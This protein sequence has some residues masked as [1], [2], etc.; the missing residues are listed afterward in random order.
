MRQF[1][2]PYITNDGAYVM[3][4]YNGTGIPSIK[5][6]VVQ[7][8]N[9]GVDSTFIT[10]VANPQGTV[11]LCGYAMGVVYEAGIAVGQPCRVVMAGP[12]DVRLENGSRGQPLTA[13]ESVNGSGAGTEYSIVSPR[14]A[15]GLGV[16]R[17]N[18]VP[19][20]LTPCIIQVQHDVSVY[21]TGAM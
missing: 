2:D 7:I 17:Q 1:L 11:G 4:L 15:Q 9:S 14:Y 3:W 19:A 20:G 6:A 21:I 12:A 16:L 5:G 18:F 13:H 10:A 8:Y